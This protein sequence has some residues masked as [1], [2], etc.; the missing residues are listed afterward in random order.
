MG[1]AAPAPCPLGQAACGHLAL[2]SCPLFVCGGG[3]STSWDSAQPSSPRPPP[4]K[5]QL[6]PPSTQEGEEA[7][8]P[9][10]ILQPWPLPPASHP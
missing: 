7:R 8:A 9:A 3:P 4:G 2:S 5:M 1:R 10:P 6:A